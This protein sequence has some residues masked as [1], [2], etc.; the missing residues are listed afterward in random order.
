MFDE[1]QGGIHAWGWQFFCLEPGSLASSAYSSF[2]NCTGAYAR[3]K[4]IGPTYDVPDRVFI[5]GPYSDNNL[6]AFIWPPCYRRVLS[7]FPSAE[8]GD[9]VYF[10]QTIQ[11][12][13]PFINHQFMMIYLLCVLVNK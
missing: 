12:I 1:S 7:A 2:S 6:I 3:Y 4:A 13:V 10:V 8:Y 5:G 9:D 11:G